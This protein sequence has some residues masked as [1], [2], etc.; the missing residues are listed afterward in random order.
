MKIIVDTR[1]Q[2]PWSFPPEVEVVRRALPAGDYAVAGFEDAAVVERKSL[3]DLIQS[4]TWGRPRFERELE[5]LRP[6]PHR[7]II[8]EGS[9]TDIVLGNYRSKANPASLLGSICA[10]MVDFGIPF[11]FAG[12]RVAAAAL[13]LKLLSKAVSRS[14]TANPTRQDALQASKLV[15]CE[16]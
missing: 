11:L 3:P 5:R 13:C 15:P 10:L 6:V 16:S 2:M 7:F 8:I 4:L 14:M 12:S 1:E 9:L